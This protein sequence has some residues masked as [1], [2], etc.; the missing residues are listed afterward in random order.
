MVQGERA[1]YDAIVNQKLDSVKLFRQLFRP[2]LR[3]APALLCRR[4][5]FVYI[6]SSWLR[7]RLDS[8]R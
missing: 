4:C 8:T 7:R 1:F 2:R 3:H 5:R 6:R